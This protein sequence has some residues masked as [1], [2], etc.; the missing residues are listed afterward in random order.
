MLTP[1]QELVLL[2]AGHFESSTKKLDKLAESVDWQ[3]FLHATPANPHPYLA[4]RIEQTIG[5]SR[6]TDNAWNV[7]ADARRANSMGQLQRQATLRK[8]FAALDAAGIPTMVVKGMALAYLVYADPGLRPMSDIDL[9][10]QPSNLDRATAAL[11]DAG[12]QHP[13]RF[14]EGKGDPRRPTLMLEQP[15]TRGLVELHGELYSLNALPASWV[16]QAWNSKIKVLLGGI[17]SWVLDPRHTLVHLSLHYARV[18]LFST[19]LVGLIDIFLTVERWEDDW[20]WPKMAAS[21]RE[22]GIENWMYLTLHLAR[23]MLGAPVPDSF[24]EALGQPDRIDEMETLA[25]RQVWEGHENTLFPALRGVLAT[26]SLR[27]RLNYLWQRM[28]TFYLPKKDKSRNPFTN[29]VRFGRSAIFDLSVKLPRYM[30]AWKRGDLRGS[31]RRRRIQLA[32]QRGHLAQLVEQS[33]PAAGVQAKNTA[34][35]T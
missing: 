32:K 29:A 25:T 17:E 15:G 34:G 30:A 26:T 27:D 11:L 1:Q 16:E 3:A 24:F 10:V 23:K 12:L 19:G 20:D 35:T 9:W 28:S 4:Y 31:E 21:Y 22:L 13:T 6:L 14:Y 8:M 33:A 5:P 7:L 2:L 18:H